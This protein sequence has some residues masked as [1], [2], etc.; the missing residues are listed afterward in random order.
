MAINLSFR[1]CLSTH[2][3]YKEYETHKVKKSLA[4]FGCF[5]RCVL[6]PNYVKILLQGAVMPAAGAVGEGR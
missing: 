2:K 3:L 1:K 5:V 6:I 4:T